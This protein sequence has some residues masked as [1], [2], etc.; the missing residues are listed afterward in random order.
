MTSEI[1]YFKVPSNNFFNAS[2]SADVRT[3]LQ[4]AVKVIEGKISH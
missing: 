4:K 3:S 1:P 2:A